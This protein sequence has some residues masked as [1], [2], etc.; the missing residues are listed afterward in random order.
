LS[1]KL[2]PPVEFEPVTGEKKRESFQECEKFHALTK[3][4]TK[5]LHASVETF[6]GMVFEQE[7]AFTVSARGKIEA[8]SFFDAIKKQESMECILN[9]SLP[10]SYIFFKAVL[11]KQTH[12]E[13]YFE[14]PEKVFQV[15]RRLNSRLQ[16]TDLLQFWVEFKAKH[17]K[18]KKF[19]G[20]ILDINEK[21]IGFFLLQPDLLTSF[22]V[23]TR[24]Q[25]FQFTLK[26]HKIT[27]EAEVR[28]IRAFTPTS[29]STQP[30]I[31]V[32]VL[33]INIS[34]SDSD[35]IAAYV[36][37]EGRKFYSRFL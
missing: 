27:V 22:P 34:Q 16:V 36:F 23:G 1:E 12:A 8:K 32:G 30:G 14:I 20:K 26:N 10:N 17:L 2:S 7:N 18:Q 21:G 13:L 24:L 37:E 33:F 11:K 35:L 3:V 25:D 9:I 6:F 15:Q 28:N 5:G 4:W 19:K 29:G 31:R